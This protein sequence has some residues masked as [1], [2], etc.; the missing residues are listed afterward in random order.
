MAQTTYLKTTES[1]GTNNLFKITCRSK[2]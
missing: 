1:Y 2:R